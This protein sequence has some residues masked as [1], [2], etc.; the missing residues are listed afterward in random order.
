MPGRGNRKPKGIGANVL[1]AVEKAGG[2]QDDEK[3]TTKGGK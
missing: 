3:R 2:G 1:R